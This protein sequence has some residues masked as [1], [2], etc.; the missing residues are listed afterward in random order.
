[1]K[2]ILI[3]DDDSMNCV[4]AKRALMQNYHIMEVHSGKEALAFLETE[5]PDLI[6]M[7][8]EMPEMNGIETVTKIKENNKWT[9]IPV[10]FLTADANPMTE[11]ECLNCGADDFITKPFVPIVMNSRVSRIIEL[12]EF[13]KDLEQQL[14][15]KTLKSLTDALTGLHN[16]DY[17]QSKLEEL[18]NDGHTGTLFMIDLDNFKTINDTYGHIVGDKTLQHFADVLEKY[19]E[20]KD[21]V[22]RLAGDEFVVFYTDMTDRE[23]VAQKAEGIIRAFAEKMG[24]LGYAGI[25]SVSIGAMITMG[26]ESFQSM[27]SK[28]DKSLYF[29]KNNGKNAYHFFDEHN[30]KKN[31]SVNE[32]NTNADLKDIRRMIEEGVDAGKGAFHLAYDEFRNVYDFVLRCVERKKQKVQIVL[33]TISQKKD[34]HTDVTLEMLMDILKESVISSLRAMDTGTKYSSSQYILILMDTDVENGKGVAERVIKKFYENNHISKEDVNIIF[35]IQTIG[36]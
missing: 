1:M 24:W 26:K 7:D 3:V 11:V 2:R 31:L 6:L 16:R 20:E 18:L 35:D 25:V 4:M 15:K 23:V 29:V 30:E 8:I 28:A 10:I 33:F 14:E 22:C 34:R 36:L 5:I 19:A 13:R 32:I 21:I 27:Y 9:K 17:L 12:Q